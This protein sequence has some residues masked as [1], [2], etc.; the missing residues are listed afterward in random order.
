MSQAAPM[1]KFSV[2]GAHRASRLPVLVSCPGQQW[3]CRQTVEADKGEGEGI[4]PWTRVFLNTVDIWGQIVL[5]HYRG[6]AMHRRMV[7]SIPGLCPHQGD[8][9]K[10]LQTSPPPR[11]EGDQVAPVWEPL[12]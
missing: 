3:K 2:E 11:A 1:S 6:C 9:P 4:S 5:W 10:C 12:Q 8:N 7:S